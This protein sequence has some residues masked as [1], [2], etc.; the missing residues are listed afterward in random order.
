[1][2]PCW[3]ETAFLL[4]GP[5]ELNAEERLCVQLWDS[6]RTSADDDLGK[7]EVALKEL[8]SD[9]GSVSQMKHRSDGFQTLSRSEA[10]P[11]KLNW[12][13]GYFPKT[14]IQVE[15]LERQSLEPEVKSM[16]QLKGLVA[17]DVRRKMREALS[18][19]EATEFGQQEAQDLKI[20]EGMLACALW[21]P[22]AKI[23]HR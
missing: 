3:E 12:A 4:V 1:M 14:R 22:V 20:R 9:S 2:E 11:G 18:R 15:Q 6:D 19:G 8:M 23:L 10:M 21:N 17:K 7:V 16:Q 5:N 13:V